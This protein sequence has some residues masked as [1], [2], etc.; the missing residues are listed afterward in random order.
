MTEPNRPG[1][2]APASP[3]W[4]EIRQGFE[5]LME[6]PP[7][8]RVERLREMAGSNPLLAR[9][10][11]RLLDH[12]DRAGGDGFEE[13]LASLPSRRL[14]EVTYEAEEEDDAQLLSG[15]ARVGPYRLVERIGRGGSGTVYRARRVDGAYDSWVAIKLLRRGLDTEDLLARFRAE[16]QILAA[17]A[18]PNIARLLDGGELPDGRP[19]LVMEHVEGERIDDHCAR[20][21]CGVRER[22]Q[23]FLQVC[24]AVSHAHRELVLHRDLKPSNILVDPGGTVHLLDFGIAKLIDPDQTPDASTQT[25]TGIRLFTPDYAAPEQLQGELAG[26]STDVHQLGTL[27]CRLLTG[28]LPHDVAPDAGLPE[29]QEAILAGRTRRP[30]ELAREERRRRS[31]EEA[32]RIG[33]G[34]AGMEEGEKGSD[35]DAEPTRLEPVDPRALLGDLDVIVDKA[36]R[37]EPGERYRSVDALAADVRAHLT[38]H[39]IQACP[40]SL[41]Y[42]LR[43]LARRNP[44]GIAAGILGALLLVVL[45]TG[46]TLWAVRSQA[47]AGELQRERDRAEAAAETAEEVTEFLLD[48]FRASGSAKADTLTARTLLARGTERIDETLGERPRLRSTLMGTMA[49]AHASLGL[50]EQA[51]PLALARIEALRALD[52]DPEDLA[53]ALNFA[54]DLF[55]NSDPDRAEELLN[56]A[57]ELWIEL[58]GVAN[59]DWASAMNNLGLAAH[60]RGELERA[61]DHFRMA[62]H[63]QEHHPEGSPYS[64]AIN[65]SN[66]ARSQQAAGQLEEALESLDV[67]VELLEAEGEGAAGTLGVTLNIMGVVHR[68]LGNLEEAEGAYRRSIEARKAASGERHLTV[69]NSLYN[70]GVLLRGMERH[71]DALEALEEAAGI[72]AHELGED[73]AAVISVRAEI[74]V[75][76]HQLGNLQLAE[77][78]LRRAWE[79]RQDNPPLETFRFLRTVQYAGVLRDLDRP[80]EG[81]VVLR[82]ILPE[83]VTP[84]EPN[85]RVASVWHELATM[86]LRRGDPWAAIS[87]LEGVVAVREEG[88][89]PDHEITKDSRRL[90]EEAR[91]QVDEEPEP[92][93]A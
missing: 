64:R 70:L 3:S 30:S 66:L 81:E 19:Y 7:E 33:N 75:L 92:A 51:Q 48:L 32:P 91:S 11:G 38:G 22:L 40:P 13:D 89:G 61:M 60:T 76:H 50:A 23:L 53:D 46:S 80:E 44:S 21:T 68:H 14:R 20:H 77:E 78:L 34:V 88:A 6:R 24:E 56:E 71:E 85:M 27:L 37:P 1:E 72:R 29:L 10:V 15:D 58:Q 18:H 35:S 9:E 54:G 79:F 47:Q 43:K 42:R 17:L 63:V 74:G 59:P 12:H 84:D 36:T 86:K 8:D 2:D 31:G 82:E 83:G 49:R 62:A 45:V 26:V 16:R 5:E 73:H 41:P 28:R 39:P 4:P 55:R 25:R 87:I 90:L 52:S 67:A 93:G 69:A 57:A 65:L